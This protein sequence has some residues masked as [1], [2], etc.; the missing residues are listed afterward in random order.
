MGGGA[1]RTRPD[2]GGGGVG[3][4]GWGLPF[5]RGLG[6]GVA[7]WRVRG[8]ICPPV[9]SIGWEQFGRVPEWPNGTDCKSVGLRLRGFESLLAHCL[10]RGFAHVLIDL[11]CANASEVA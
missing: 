4:V 6:E 8:Y 10:D 5:A 3:G 9:W 1:A 11:C 2:S 7:A